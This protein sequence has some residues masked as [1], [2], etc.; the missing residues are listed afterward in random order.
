MNYSMN[1]VPAAAEMDALL[2]SPQQ[3]D[4]SARENIIRLNIDAAIK[5]IDGDVLARMVQDGFSEIAVTTG[6]KV[7]EY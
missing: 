1:G 6:G 2:L 7:Y 3:S 5:N 4:T